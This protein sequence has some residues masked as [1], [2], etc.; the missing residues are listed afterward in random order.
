MTNTIGGATIEMAVDSSGVESGLDRV[1]GA[2]RRTGR[3]L[4]SLRTQG[5]GALDSIGT[6]G[7]AAANRVDAATRN[8][9]GAVERANAALI[10]GKKSGAEYFEELGR[11]RGADM[12]K[13]APLIAQLRETEAAQARAKTATEAAAT[14]QQAAAEAARAQAVAL[15]EVAQAQAGKDS[16][17]A[18][19]REQIALYGKSTEEVLRYRAAQAGA[20]EAAGPLILQLQNMRA[21]HEAIA[22]SARMEAQAHRQV[23]QAQVKNDSFLAGLREQVALYGKSTEEVLR[24]KAAQAGASSA[25]EP[26]IQ[27]LQ[28]LRAA[29]EAATESARLAAAAQQQA[30]QVQ[31]N[32]DSFL[33]GLR[34]QITLYGK[35]TEEVLRYKAAQLGVDS[36]AEPQIQELKRLKA[37]HDAVTEAARLA[38]AVQQ[39]ASQA[40]ANRDT[41]LA[42]LREQ[43]ALYGKSTEEVLRYRAAQAGTAGAAEP[44]ISELLRLKTVQD[45]VAEATRLATAAQAQA[46]Q[47]QASGAALVA[48]LRE[49]VALYGK[50][51]EEVSR[52]RAAQAGVAGAAEP[53]IQELQRLKAA[54][55]AATAAAKASV[56]AQRTA[57]QVQVKSDSF[58]AGLREQIALYGKSTEEVLRYKAAQAGAATAAEP[59]IQELQ[60]LKVAQDAATE[61][62]RLATAA[63]VQAAQVQSNRDSLLA[64]LREQIALYGKS[65]EEVLRYRAAQA[66][67]AGAAEP[68]IQELQRL[69]I[70]QDAVTEAARIAAAA[71]QLAAQQLAA[72][73]ALVAGLREQIALYGKTTE[74]VLRYKAAQAG[75]AGA[76]EPHIQELARLK[77]AEDAV[78][79]AA[80]AAAEAQRQA[81]T[82]QTG[83]DSFVAGLQQQAAAIG[84]TRA[85]LLELQAAQMGVTAQAAPFIAKLREVEQGLNHAGMSARATAAAM[86][87]VPAQF[88]DIIVSIQ[89][90]QNPLTVLLQQ[91]GQLKDMFGG[92]GNAAKALGGYIL[93]LITPFTIAAA[94]GV[95]LVVAFIQG[96]NEAIAYSKALILAGNTATT[97]SGQLS[98]M[99]RNIS[100]GVGTQG[101][102]AEAVIA[103]AATG[104]VTAGNLEQ[105]SATAIKAQRALGQSVG[106][107]AA[108]FA[109]L[110][111]APVATLLKLDETFHFLTADVYKQVKALELQ[112][113]TVEAGTMAQKE[114]NRAL[115][116]VSGK[117]TENLSNLQ[118]TWKFVGDTAKAAWD[119]MLNV[120]RQDSVT[121]QLDKVN[122]SIS[123]A[124][125]PFDPSVGGNSEDRMRLA[126]NI[127]L[128]AVLEG[129]IAAEKAG[130]APKEAAN[131]LREAGLKWAQDEEKYLTRVQLRDQEI[132]RTTKLGAVIVAADSKK[133]GEVDARLAAIKLRYADTYNL[134]IDTQIELLKRRGAVEEESAKRSMITLNADRAAGL[135]TSLLAEFEYAD[136][137]AK[138]DLDALARK[139]ALLSAELALTAAKPNSKKEQAGLTAAIAEVD[140]Q[141]L[142]RTLQ[143]KEDIRVLDIKDTKQGLAN[144]ADLAAARATDLQSLQ[145]QLQAQKD[146]NA[147]IGLSAVETDKFNQS[148]VEETAKRLENKAALIGGSEARAAEAA[149]L[150]AS[151]VLVRA[152]GA[153]KVEG[154]DLTAAAKAKKDLDD[155]LDPAKAKNFGD[156]LRDAF[157]GAGSSLVKLT[158]SF[159]SYA[160]KQAEFDK[161]RDNAEKKRMSGRGTEA[162]YIKDIT[163]L[164]RMQASEQ[165]GSYGDMAGAA[166]GF[167]NEQSSGYKALQAVSQAFHLAQLAMNLASI[168][169]AIAAGAAQMFAQSGWGGFAGVAA[170]IGVMAALGAATSGGGGGPSAKDRQAANGTGTILGD[171]SAKSE[172]I[173]HSLAIM[174]KNSG[175]GL[176]HTIS[177]DQSLKQMV[178]GIGNLGNLLARSGI[179]AAGAGATAGIATGSTPTLGKVGQGVLTGAATYGGAVLGGSIAGAMTMGTIGSSLTMMGAVAGPIGMAIGAAIGFVVSKLIKTSVSVKD[180]GITGAATS[181]GNVDALGF[182]AQA[183][184]DIN[185]KKKAFG[186]SYS[187]KNSTQK[188]TL[189]D[190]MNDQ[191]TMIITSMGDT[192]RSAADVLGLGGAAFNAHLNSFVVDLGKISLK[193]L[194]AEEQQKVLETAFSK[195]GDD[196]AKF[197]VAG[198]AQ[199]Q[200]VGEGYLE[201]LVRVTNDF[202]QVSDVLAVLGK[203][204]NATGLGAVALSESLITA[205]GGLEALTSGTSYFVENFLTEAERMAPITKSVNDAMGKLGVSGV[206]TVDQ[207]K[208]LVLAQDLNTAAGQSMY[209]Q[210]IAIAEPFK[211]AA[212]YA[213]ELAAATGDLAAVNK[214]ASEIASERKDLQQQLNE[215]TKSETALLSIQRD[216]IA[217]VNRA[218]FD[219]V[220]AAKAVV[221]AKDALGKAY[222]REAAAAQ[223]ALDKS[224]SWVSTLNGLN[225]SMALGAQS[226]LTPEQ[227]YA[228]A[229]AQFEKTLAAANAGDTTAQ[230]GLSAAEQAFLTASQ[231]VNASDARYAADYARVVAANNEALKWASAQVDV[232]QASLDALK[233][234][235]SGLITINDSVL[236]VA[237]AIANLHTAMGTATGLGVK[238]DGSHAGGLANVPF[239]GYAAELHRGE[240]VMDAPAASVMRRYFGGAPSQGGGNTDALVAEI[241]SLREEVKGLRADQDK[242]TGAKIQAT[243]E[244]SDKAA[245]TIVAGVDKSAKSSA[246]ANTVKGEYA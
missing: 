244:S 121:E 162:E 151:A 109:D 94:A 77:L 53:F 132:D 63:Q 236:T 169:P 245:K 74:E 192:I 123:K 116:D 112:G 96:R 95:A 145:S 46:A 186:V 154:V 170:M 67:A 129:Q 135:A 233:A 142:T 60:R 72:G 70:A 76:A 58:V 131:K 206:T 199:Y 71:Q 238:F 11:S 163:A 156:S 137:V 242:Q 91:G 239:D 13:L 22:E 24:Y 59:Q 99:A 201:T 205:A 220:Q 16:Y 246:W 218:L 79:A 5:G 117:V 93:T 92:L 176:A 106:D 44:L 159:Q 61:A 27:K 181:L 33:A 126:A 210:L 179:T 10:S 55:D 141:A 17:V 194:S 98:D 125:R 84:K 166:A 85:D 138:I 89:G 185:V 153:K 191:F 223:T 213:A 8:I 227:K 54:Q 232:Q 120:G 228:E 172:S 180:S 197:G 28:Q 7:T 4:D 217:A 19:L 161:Q 235:V 81:A 69:K 6:G 31:A 230:S 68:L 57:A 187:S 18:G 237:Q 49:Q 30:A 165:L 136:K 188:A 167:F 43:I 40:Q 80:K 3:T 65:T 14:A 175:L 140:A 100:K 146:A 38:T 243:V 168:G 184:A 212:D 103:M 66:G 222:D 111:K 41:F 128:K 48:G 9:A 97:T 90:G 241:K 64:G 234:Q 229:R 118:K 158:T 1:D 150:R 2:V 143:L 195:M 102:A 204:F 200:A 216:G 164:N 207:F 177:M 101:A 56:E 127:A 113:R 189:S 155:F 15:R 224:K 20:A 148:L 160:Q 130:I 193:D 37:A 219:Q 32:R 214:T 83:R 62:T 174:E 149:D 12:M 134:A 42:G 157:G 208:A 231:V 240:V 196:M 178:A 115:G 133:Q 139:K 203:S 52:Y 105:F 171:S 29:Q 114:W 173:A 104:K 215:L 152:L 51:T 25:A 124:Q 88:T 202:M 78:T 108:Q 34:E 110:G 26:Q 86:R 23:A 183:Y 21:A 198:L 190:E 35:S 107:T 82:A 87:G 147:L 119:S 226:T 45:G 47:V 75:V 50:S 36:A 221:S 225:A 211:T 144:I 122:K 39:Q 73:P 182:N 209:A